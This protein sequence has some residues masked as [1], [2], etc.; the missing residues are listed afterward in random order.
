M[1]LAF[2]LGN[3][4]LPA[5]ASRFSRH[6][7]TRSQLFPLPRAQ[8]VL[9]ARLPRPRRPARGLTGRAA[10]RRVVAGPASQH[11]VRRLC[12]APPRRGLFPRARRTGQCL[13]EHGP[14]QTRPFS[15]GRRQFD[16]REP[17]RQPTLRAAAGTDEPP[18]SRHGCVPSSPSAARS[19]SRPTTSNCSPAANLKSSHSSPA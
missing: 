16:V 18:A 1:Q 6:D 11:V 14:A 3:K 17:P 8:A 4:H 15:R 5:Y 12:Q 10:G 2:R 9:Q 19:T 7:L 13:R